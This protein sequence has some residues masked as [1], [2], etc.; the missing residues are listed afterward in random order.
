MRSLNEKKPKGVV[1][2]KEKEE[3]QPVK[4]SLH[5]LFTNKPDVRTQKE[6]K[7]KLREPMIMKDFSPEMEMFVRHL[8]D[9]GYFQDANFAKGKP[10]FDLCWFETYFARGYIKFAAQKFAIDNQQIAKWLSGSALKQVAVFGCPAVDR[11]SVFPA[12]RLRRFFEVP[13]DTVCSKCM[14]RESC[15]F[16]NQSVWKCD[17]SNL[18]LVVVMKVV[19]SYALGLVHPE[20]VVTDEVNKSVSQLLN[21]FVKLSQTT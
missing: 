2:K 16:I 3:K 7:V 12:K 1:P 5:S 18:Y 10:S 8:F 17:T 19:T 14:L 11:N 15:K 13:E 6:K 9:N 20:L 4:I 21:E